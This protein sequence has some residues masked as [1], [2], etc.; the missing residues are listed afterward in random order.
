VN[1]IR[2]LI[3]DHMSA[4]ILL[5][6]AMTVAAALVLALSMNIQQFSLAGS[7]KAGI[8]KKISRNKLWVVGL[9]VYLVAQCL[10]IVALGLGVSRTPFSLYHTTRAHVR[11]HSRSQ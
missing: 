1:Q 4:T 5:G 3:I 7:E 10:F 11:A 6:M 2:L 9:L 8:F